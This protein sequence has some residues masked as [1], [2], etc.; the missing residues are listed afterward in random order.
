MFPSTMPN[1]IQWLMYFDLW[2]SSFQPQLSKLSKELDMQHS[3]ISSL[4]HIKSSVY[5]SS[6]MIYE[7]LFI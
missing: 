3:F 7:V 6:L 5:I 1:H 2:Q 4:V